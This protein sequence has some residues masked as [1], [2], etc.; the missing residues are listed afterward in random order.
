MEPT[1][2]PIDKEYLTS[3]FQDFDSEVLSKKYLQSNDEQLHTHANKE[4]LDKL[5]LSDDGTLL[6]NGNEIGSS[7]STAA[8]KSAYEIAQEN[9]FEGTV[10]EWLESLKGRDGTNGTDGTDGADGENGTD[11][12]DGKSAYEIAVQNGFEGTEPEWLDSLKG[13][14]ID[15]YTKE[16]TD[17]KFVTAPQIWTGS[18]QF[19]FGVDADGNY[20]YYKAGADTV[21]PFKKDSSIPAAEPYGLFSQ[22]VLYSNSLNSDGFFT[23]EF[24]KEKWSELGGSSYYASKG[25]ATIVLF[26]GRRTGNAYATTYP[27]FNVSGNRRDETGKVVTVYQRHSYNAVTGT[28]T[29]NVYNYNPI[30]SVVWES[31]NPKIQPLM[32]TGL[33]GIGDRITVSD[34]LLRPA[35]SGYIGVLI[36]SNVPFL[37]NDSNTTKRLNFAYE[38]QSI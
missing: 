6:F 7:T 12:K 8:G 20:G 32:L 27:Y 13:D 9:G 35:N 22:I 26:G 3:L 30:S 25:A 14:Q 23:I 2:K 19:K 4:V 38:L 24:D 28:S 29:T 5:D 36:T 15:A 17:T 1:R 33:A 11:G 34:Y 18:N 31:F 37:I 16:E 21:T 10:S